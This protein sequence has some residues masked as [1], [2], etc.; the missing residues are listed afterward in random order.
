MIRL[1]INDQ[2]IGVS[3]FPCVA[4]CWGMKRGWEMYFQVP[5]LNVQKYC[6]KYEYW[7]ERMAIGHIKALFFIWEVWTLLS[8]KLLVDK[9]AVQL[10]GAL[11]TSG[12]HG[13]KLSTLNSSQQLKKLEDKKNYKTSCQKVKLKIFAKGH[14][15]ENQIYKHL[16][17]V[18]VPNPLAH[19]RLPK[20]SK[21]G[22]R[23]V[24]RFRVCNESQALR[25]HACPSQG[26]LAWPLAR[27]GHLRLG[28][29][30][31]GLCDFLSCVFLFLVH[32]L[33]SVQSTT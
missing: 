27:H 19:G 11:I 7:P 18:R 24:L 29:R 21:V 9:A 10:R 6:L 4:V 8:L 25:H 5:F 16:V 20:A 13:Q 23:N 33:C 1:I 32:C 17:T 2:K 12:W 28:C 30:C 3:I 26:H 14:W 22:V 31:L 15:C